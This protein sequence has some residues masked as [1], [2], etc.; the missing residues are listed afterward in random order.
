MIMPFAVCCCYL[1]IGIALCVT[2]CFFCGTSYM[3]HCKH[4]DLFGS[5]LVVAQAGG[6]ELGVPKETPV[7]LPI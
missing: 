5:I 1:T 6:L 4:E 7:C 2:L 3:Q